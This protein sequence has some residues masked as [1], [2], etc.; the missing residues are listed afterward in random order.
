MSINMF[1]PHDTP[2]LKQ[3]LLF[4][5]RFNWA[6]CC[7]TTTVTRD[8]VP[9]AAPAKLDALLAGLAQTASQGLSDEFTGEV[10]AKQRVAAGQ[11]PF[12]LF[13]RL[14]VRLA[15]PQ[16]LHAYDK[17][18]HVASFD[19][20]SVRPENDDMFVR[21]C[22]TAG[23]DIVTLDFSLRVNWAAVVGKNV[24]K[25]VLREAYFE[26]CCAPAFRSKDSDRVSFFSNVRK[27]VQA[28]RGR[29]LIL[30]LDAKDWNETRGPLDLVNLGVVCGM[31]ERQ[32]REAVFDNP[33][34]CLERGAV[35]AKTWRA[36]VGVMPEAAAAHVETA[37]DNVADEGQ[38]AEGEEEKKKKKKK[39]K[40]KD[41]HEKREKGE[42]EMSR[43]AMKKQRK[44]VL[45]FYTSK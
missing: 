9:T 26:V 22:E 21:C 44:E 17:S 1:V 43:R 40:K 7:I 13:T 4:L 30:S 8:K 36:A 27:L 28:V 10:L 5:M 3:V 12:R 16:D 41:V 39:K 45:N 42:G 29:N 18:P 25:L 2:A 31:T 37:F 11:P 38:A 32:A 35:R 24:S 23:V 34:R 6:G 33:L 14:V 20:L 19:V 15:N